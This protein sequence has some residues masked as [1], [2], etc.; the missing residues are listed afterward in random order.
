M[1]RKATQKF[2]KKA[3]EQDKM[4]KH[5]DE[6]AESVLS[7]LM[8]G[9]IDDGASEMSGMMRVGGGDAESD[10]TGMI[11]VAEAADEDESD[12]ESAAIPN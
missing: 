10:A 3:D 9:N 8:E 4:Q 12:S 5:H 7:G 1:M 11:K 6:D 2:E